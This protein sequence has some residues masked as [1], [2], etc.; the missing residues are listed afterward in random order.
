MTTQR[1]LSHDRA[2][3][4]ALAV[5]GI[6]TGVLAATSGDPLLRLLAVVLLAGAAA[7]CFRVF[8]RR[9]YAYWPAW[10]ASAAVAALLAQP[11]TGLFRV[12]PLSLAA[13]EAAV[14]LVLAAAWYRRRDG[15][16]DW[17]VWLPDEGTVLRR[18]WSR[19]A[20]IRWAEGYGERC[21]IS[22]AGDFPEVA[23]RAA[24]Y[25]DPDRPHRRG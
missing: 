18:E 13:V 23:G 7:G 19:R 17:L 5:C 15:R 12:L 6:L 4:G 1:D 2:A 8:P 10:L 20:A 21:E 11:H 3:V 9:P 22:R 16:G 24:L 25:P 14:G